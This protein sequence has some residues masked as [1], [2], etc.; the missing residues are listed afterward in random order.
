MDQRIRWFEDL[1]KDD[2][3]V[4][5]GKGANLG[6][7]TRPGCRCRPG[8]SSPRRRTSKRSISPACGPICA[9]GR[10]NADQLD[11]DALAALVSDLRALVHKAG[12]PAGAAPAKC[13]TRITDSAPNELVA[14]RSSATGEDSATSSFA[15]MNE[16]FTN[17]HGDEELLERIVDCWASLFSARASRTARRRASRPSRRSRSSCSA[18]STRS[19]PA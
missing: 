9:S 10:P 17:V 4:A 12:I 19:A 18:W 6:E 5:G 16:T 14:V 2:V 13:S 8:S 11:E 7:L 15:G 3:D 1:G